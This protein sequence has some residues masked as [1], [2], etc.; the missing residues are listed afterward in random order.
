VPLYCVKT[1]KRTSGLLCCV[2]VKRVTGSSRE[3]SNGAGGSVPKSTMTSGS[4][5]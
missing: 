3:A 5:L 4:F 2:G 1:K